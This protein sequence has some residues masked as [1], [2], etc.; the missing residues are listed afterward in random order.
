MA[1]NDVVEVILR[2]TCVGQA[3]VNVFHY[4]QIA[5]TGTD[6]AVGLVN[7]FEDTVIDALQDIIPED[8]GYQSVEYK[9]VKG[10]F[11]EG[12]LVLGTTVGTRTGDTLPPYAAWSFRFLRTLSDSRG[13][14]K[15]IGGIAEP[16]QVDGVYTGGI[17]TNLQAAAVAMGVQLSTVGGNTWRP[18]VVSLILNGIERTEPLINPVSGVQ[19]QRITTQNSRKFGRGI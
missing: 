17:I 18:V 12:S 10:T 9:S 1:I 15:R 4:E 3:T 7:S 16:D 5:G 19:F 13:G 8:V 2:G 11:Y 14:Y 6:G